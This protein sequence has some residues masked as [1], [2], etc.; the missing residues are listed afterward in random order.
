MKKGNISAKI[1]ADSVSAV[2]NQRITTFELE[3]PR[4][5]HA[6]VMTHRQ[7]SRNSASSRAIPISTVIENIENNLAMPEHWGKNKSGMQANE[8][9][10]ELVDGHLKELY[11]TSAAA[12]AIEFAENFAKAGYHKQLVNRLLEPFQMIKVLV[13]STN[14][15][16]FYNLRIHEDAQPEIRI[17]AE[18]MYE[19]QSKSVPNQLNVGDWHL[20]YY[21]DAGCWKADVNFA[22]NLD[23]AIM[24]SCSCAAQISYRKNDQSLEKAKKIY[25]MLIESEPVHA[26]A[27]EHAA[28]PIDYTD[29]LLK[30]V[31]HVSLVSDEFCSGNFTNWIQYRQLI[32]HNYCDDY[33]PE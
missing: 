32:P 1:V 30:G 11:W 17:L 19:A 18:K 2:T 29:R 5:I 13:T 6:E 12:A 20:P 14:F 31:T 33:Q 21:N 7:F 23:D 8:E 26:S 22:E 9:I 3:Y 25:N 4:F 10:N 28:T 24:I 16:N 15:D 27:F